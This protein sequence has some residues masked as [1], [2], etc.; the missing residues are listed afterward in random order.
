LVPEFEE[1][2]RKAAAKAAEREAKAKAKVGLA[3]FIALGRHKGTRRIV[4]Q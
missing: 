1:R 3:G 4:G 2:E